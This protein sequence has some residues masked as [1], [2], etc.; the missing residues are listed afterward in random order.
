MMTNLLSRALISSTLLL[1]ILQLCLASPSQ[2]H[3]VSRQPDPSE[4]VQKF[5]TSHFYG[6]KSFTAA[7]IKRKRSWL[8]PELYDL[9]IAEASRKYTPDTVP[10]I[11][12]DPFT[13]SQD[14]PQKFVVGKSDV[15]A[16]KAT[17]DLALHWISRGKITERRAYKVELTNKSGSWLISNIVYRP[18]EDLIGLLKHQR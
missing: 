16:E 9:L 15:S 17:V 10:D 18:N 7:G 11:E 1:S 2:Q 3:A 8:S 4:V 12:G 6:N 14:Y 13:D 5:Y